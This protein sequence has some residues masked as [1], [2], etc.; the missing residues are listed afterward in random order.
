MEIIRLTSLSESQRSQI[1]Q[2]QQACMAFDRSGREL[3][4]S[5]DIN[6]HKKMPCFFLCNEGETLIGVLVVFA[7]T[8]E[9]AELSAYV[10]PDH[11]RSGVFSRLLLA[12]WEEL[13]GFG[14]TKY[15]MV[16][17]AAG[18]IGKTIMTNWKAALSH[19]EYELVYRGGEAQ[20]DFPFAVDCQV[21][22]AASSD[23]AEMV[24]INMAGFGE[25]RDSATHLVRENFNHDLTRCFVGQTGDRIFGLANVR[26][27]GAGYY[28]CGFVVA[29]AFRGKGMGRYLLYRILEL[30]QPDM[31]E[32]ITLEVDST[33][34]P[35]YLLY[36]SSG[37]QVQSQ[38]DYHWLQLPIVSE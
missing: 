36:L 14:I 25:D 6:Y 10:H 28:I 21:R 29:P 4:L 17:D 20:V 16:V 2:L 7:P 18:T 12:S 27:E 15:L 35:A 9:T 24:E 1:E 31:G 32:Q 30:I 23:L 8:K 3:F 26:K 38:A 11:R 19:S 5:N 33:N 34:Q 13:S 22:E 37:F